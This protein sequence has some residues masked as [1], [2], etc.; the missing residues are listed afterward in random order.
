VTKAI[1]KDKRIGGKGK[2]AI[3]GASEVITSGPEMTQLAYKQ[4]VPLERVARWNAD[5][6]SGW[7]SGGNEK[8]CKI[9]VF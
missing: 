2:K 6:P 3:P 4:Q 8:S 7:P 1:D 9:F 5:Y